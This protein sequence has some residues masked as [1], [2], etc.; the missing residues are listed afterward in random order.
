MHSSILIDLLKTFYE[1]QIFIRYRRVSVFLYIYFIIKDGQKGEMGVQ[2]ERG[3]IG[4]VVKGE[5]GKLLKLF[6]SV[7]SDNLNNIV[8]Y[9][10]AWKTRQKR[11]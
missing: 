3:D 5:K 10:I 9:R 1:R 4:P 11:A 2:G 7:I 6:N 8:A